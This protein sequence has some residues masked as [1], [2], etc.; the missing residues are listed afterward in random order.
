L[1]VGSGIDIVEVARIEALLRRRGG[2]FRE[3][4]FTERERA[5]C[6]RRARSGPHFALRFA[7]K[8]AGMKAVGTGWR[9]GVGW[10]DFE[11]IEAA[12]GLELRLSGRALEFAHERGGDRVWLAASTPRTHAVCEVVLE[13]TPDPTRANLR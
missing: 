1:I 2:R 6:D 9:R 10:R 11:V 5:D 8:E 7:A 3:R 13:R 12:G 4:V